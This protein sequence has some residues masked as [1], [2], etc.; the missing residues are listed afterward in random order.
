VPCGSS[1]VI[2][3]RSARDRGRRL[4]RQRPRSRGAR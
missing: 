4:R 3:W 1:P 2:C